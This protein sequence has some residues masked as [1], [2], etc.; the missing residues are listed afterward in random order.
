MSIASEI[1]RL[2]N[3]KASLKSSINAKTDAQHQIASE[4]IDDYADFVDSITT[5]GGGGEP[6]EKDVNF[7]DYDGTRLYSY[8]AQAFQAL[9]AMPENPTHEGLTA[10]G[11]NWTL[12][13]AKTYVTNHG[14][15]DIGQMYI[16]DDNA[17]R[18]YIKLYEGRLSPTLKFALNGTTIIDWGDNTTSSVTG[19][20]S[21]TLISTQH[22]YANAGDYVISIAGTT[23]ISVGGTSSSDTLIGSNRAYQNSVQKV[24]LGNV[25]WIKNYAFKNF[26]SMISITIPS[27][28]IGIQS[29]STEAFSNCMSLKNIVIQNGT[30]SIGDYA[31]MDC[32]LLKRIIMPKGINSIQMGAYQGTKISSIIIPND[33]ASMGSYIFNG[34]YVLKNV[35]LPNSMTSVGM[36]LFSSNSSLSTVVIPSGV[37]SI[38][39]SAFSSCYALVSLKIPSGVTS[40]GSN[41]FRYCQSLAYLDFSEHTSVPTLGN[42][43][44]FNSVSSDCKIIVPDNLYNDWVATNYWSNISSHIISKSD[45]DALQA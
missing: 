28:S 26:S 27:T 23:E 30:Q 25:G 20:S 10:Q 3:A 44:V 21:V 5:G 19:I 11:W 35:I 15:L 16:T 37:T 4:T 6:E 17:T 43:N 31:F 29:I 41:A 42:S 38:G 14:M 2:Q 1:T 13:D 24:E 32:S 12:S 39:D 33:N 34:C 8:T 45:W 7:Y 40:I 22:T 9:S 18:I 36:S